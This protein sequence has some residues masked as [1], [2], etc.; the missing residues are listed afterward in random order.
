MAE[1]NEV[2]CIGGK[3][4]VSQCL[5]CSAFAAVRHEK[6]RDTAISV[7]LEESAP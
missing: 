7:S 4:G 6:T 3:Y 1:E 5:E 2:S